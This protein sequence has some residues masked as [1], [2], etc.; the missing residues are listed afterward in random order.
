MN[1][2][3]VWRFCGWLILRDFGTFSRHGN[4]LLVACSTQPCGYQ[5][6]F[7][8]GS[9]ILRR[10]TGVV[11]VP[12]NVVNL[13]TPVWRH[14]QTTYRTLWMYRASVPS[15]GLLP[16]GVATGNV[17]ILFVIIGNPTPLAFWYHGK[18]VTMAS[19]VWLNHTWHYGK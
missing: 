17:R 11:W 7:T 3:T 19:G 6:L 16:S 12:D 15:I 9:S 1:L 5:L 10:C 8:H 4:I 2:V 14:S 18:S 13:T